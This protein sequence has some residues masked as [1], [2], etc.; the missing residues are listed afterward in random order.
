MVSGSGLAFCQRLEVGSLVSDD[1]RFVG[2][3]G[4]TVMG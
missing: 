4:M 1:R 3:L 2:N